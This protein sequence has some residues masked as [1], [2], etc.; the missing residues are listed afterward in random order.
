MILDQSYQSEQVKKIKSIFEEY[1]IYRCLLIYDDTI[2]FKDVKQQLQDDDFTFIDCEGDSGRL[3]ALHVDSFDYLND[4]TYDY[5]DWN[6]ITITICLGEY[7]YT[8]GMAF[9]QA[10]PGIEQV[11]SV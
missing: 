5:I 7:A 1:N 11:M 10:N 8:M 2:N 3:Y 9:F 4:A 6:T